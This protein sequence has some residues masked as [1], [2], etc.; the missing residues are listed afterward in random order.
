MKR[1]DFEKKKQDY[2]QKQIRFVNPYNFISLGAKCNRINWYEMEDRSLTGVIECT[3]DT[4]TPIFI[5]NSTNM[6]AFQ[7]KNYVKEEART[8]EFYSY[9]TIVENSLTSQMFDPVIP[10]SELRGVIRSAYEAVTD[11]C[12]STVC[13]DEVLYSRTSIPWKPGI[14]RK[15]ER[16]YYIQPSR[17][18]RVP[19]SET[20][21][22]EEGEKVYFE[23]VGKNNK[24]KIVTRGSKEGYFHRGEYFPKKKHEA[25]FMET[26]EKPIPLPQN[27]DAIEHLRKVLCLYNKEN[28]INRQENHKEYAHYKL[29]E[30]KP[31]LVYY[32]EYNGNFYLSPACISKMVFHK[33]VKEIL[34]EQGGYS[35]CVNEEVCPACALFGMVSSNRSFASRL[36]FTDGRVVREENMKGFFESPKVLSGLSSPKLSA[37]EFYLEPPSEADW[38]TYDYAGKWNGNGKNGK[39]FVVDENYKPRLRGRKFYWHSQQVKWMNYDSNKSLSPLECVIRPVKKGVKFSFRIFFDGISEVELKRLIWT[40]NIG[41]N[42]NTH[43]HKIGM[44]KPLGLGSVKIKVDRVKIRKIVLCRD[45]IEYKESERNYSIEEIESHIDKMKKNIAEF[46]RITKFSDDIRNISY[47]ITAENSAEGYKW[48][49]ENRRGEK[50]KQ[51]LPHILDDDITLK[52]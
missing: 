40:L 30:G 32:A 35:P 49:V 23:V 33:T 51:S 24:A 47:P 12:M 11:S 9:N 22:I 46:L 4:K 39:M 42:E 31:I 2:Q 5:P 45:T 10:A 21:G 34:D 16:G 8:L 13:T 50:I 20:D 26:K 3:L 28:K 15:D 44:G 41:D 43:Y 1:K 29:E 14:L 25:I 52:G 37:M 19:Q 38:W 36:R 27:F 6:N 48:F 18:Y 17:K 7:H